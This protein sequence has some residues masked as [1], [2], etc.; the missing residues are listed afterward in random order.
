MIRDKYQGV[1]MKITSIFA[2]QAV[3]VEYSQNV[4]SLKSWSAISLF[5]LWLSN[6]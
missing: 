2:W 4:K 1:A 5:N 3:A 6:D